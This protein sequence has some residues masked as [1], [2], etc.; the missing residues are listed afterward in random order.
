M[1][2]PTLDQLSCKNRA[3][4]FG[5]WG[6]EVIEGIWVIWV[7]EV[8]EGIGVIEGIL[9]NEGKKNFGNYLLNNFLA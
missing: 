9:G 7:I 5:R 2:V 1:R 8:I 6:I 3:L 4:C